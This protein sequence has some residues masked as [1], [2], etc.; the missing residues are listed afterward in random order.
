M[1]DLSGLS[2]IVKTLIAETRVLVVFDDVWDG[3]IFRRDCFDILADFSTGNLI[4]GKRARL[5]AAISRII[6]VWL[7]PCVVYT[8]AEAFI[9]SFRKQECWSITGRYH[10]SKK[11]CANILALHFS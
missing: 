9:P 2:S 6:S 8:S 3:T 4:C 10:A 5:L 1:Q 11:G 7:E